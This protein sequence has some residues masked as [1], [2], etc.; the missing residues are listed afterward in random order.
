MLLGLNLRQKKTLVIEGLSCANRYIVGYAVCLIIIF[1]DG[2]RLELFEVFVSAFVGTK[3][4]YLLSFPDADV[5][6]FFNVGPADGVLDH[7]SGSDFLFDDF[8][9]LHL[10]FL[11]VAYEELVDDKKRHAYDDKFQQHDEPRFDFEESCQ[12]LLPSIL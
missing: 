5:A 3:D 7:I 4:M 1:F 6:V 10:L 8:F 12:I 2:G 11:F 9:A